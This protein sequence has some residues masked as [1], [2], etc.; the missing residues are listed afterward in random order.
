ML[1]GSGTC[2]W[3][4]EELQRYLVHALLAR[5]SCVGLKKVC[6]SFAHE[7]EMNEPIPHSTPL[8]YNFRADIL[9]AAVATSLLRLALYLDFDLACVAFPLLRLETVSG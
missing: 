8:S 7:R 3:T 5:K 4:N 1:I 6:V 9:S 2:A